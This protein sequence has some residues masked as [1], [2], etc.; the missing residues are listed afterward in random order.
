MAM[1]NPVPVKPGLMRQ[2]SYAI[3]QS[4]PTT[5][6]S[7]TMSDLDAVA[8]EMSHSLPDRFHSFHHG[9]KR[10]NGLSLYY[11]GPSYFDGTEFKDVDE[12]SRLS[13]NQSDKINS[14]NGF[15]KGNGLS[16]YYNGPSYFDGTEFQ[17][18]DDDSCLSDNESDEIRSDNEGRLFVMNMDRSDEGNNLVDG[19]PLSE[20]KN[21]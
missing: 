4:P 14:E 16:L 13:D 7:K 18:D 21:P 19:H 3:E 12:D 8:E 2:L 1:S 11:N 9:F 6:G 10:K 20:V 17:D 15:K 5:V